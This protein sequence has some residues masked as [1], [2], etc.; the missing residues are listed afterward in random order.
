MSNDDQL[1]E[2]LRRM[3]TRSM[4]RRAA[5]V[6][7]DAAL[8]DHRVRLDSL[9]VP[10]RRDRRWLAAA[11]AVVVVAAGI[12]AIAWPRDGGNPETDARPLAERLEALGEEP[13]ETLSA[14]WWR[15]AVEASPATHFTLDGEEVDAPDLFVV[16]DVVAVNGLTGF[17]SNEGPLTADDLVDFNSSDA[18]IDIVV[19]TIEVDDG[20]AENDQPLPDQVDFVLGLPA[21][22]DLMSLEQELSGRVG[23]I[24]FRTQYLDQTLAG[25]LDGALYDVLDG[26]FLGRVQGDEVVFGEFFPPSEFFGVETVRIR[27]IIVGAGDIEMVTR[28]GEPTRVD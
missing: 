13:A 25:R 7:T 23:A 12:T 6:D 27:E 8:N 28:N 19:V 4:E 20:V 2:Q 1:A 15:G 9:R 5:A 18:V 10:D 17:S 3:A 16:G 21:P 11:A 26:Y 14:P 24:L 22:T